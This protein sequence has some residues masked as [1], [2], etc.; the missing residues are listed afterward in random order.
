MEMEGIGKFFDDTKPSSS[1]ENRLD[2]FI[3]HTCL[4]T[5]SMSPSVVAP[6]I[7]TLVHFLYG[8]SSR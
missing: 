8:W 7:A 4:A 1:T 6:Q 3:R 2:G 5:G